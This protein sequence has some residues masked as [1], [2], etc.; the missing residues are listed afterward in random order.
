MVVSQWARG[1]F[2]RARSSAMTMLHNK[3]AMMMRAIPLVLRIRR[4]CRVSWLLKPGVSA[5]LRRL[6]APP[7]GVWGILSVTTMLQQ[8]CQFRPSRNLILTIELLCMMART[9]GEKNA[10][11]NL[12]G[13]RNSVVARSGARTAKSLG[14]GR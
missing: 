5:S 12:G 2:G 1:D 10:L 9:A 3:M 11:T 6:F 8:L 7:S 13:N 4:H 14:V